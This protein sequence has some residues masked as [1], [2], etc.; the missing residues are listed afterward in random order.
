MRINE[1]LNSQP[2][3]D[4]SDLELNSHLKNLEKSNV[5]FRLNDF[6]ESTEAKI[7]QL[8]QSGDT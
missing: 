7:K 1:F 3:V 5:E 4:D 8:L 6:V 2:L